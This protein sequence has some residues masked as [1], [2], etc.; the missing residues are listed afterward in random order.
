MYLRVHFTNIWLKSCVLRTFCFWRRSGHK[1]LSFVRHWTVFKTF[2]SFVNFR[3][4][5]FTFQSLFWERVNES[6]LVF[7]LSWTAES[8]ANYCEATTSDCN[9]A[10][11]CEICAQLELQ[12]EKKTDSSD[13]P[14]CSVPPTE[15][16]KRHSV[17]CSKPPTRVDFQPAA[18]SSLSHWHGRSTRRLVIRSWEPE[19]DEFLYCNQQLLIADSSR[20]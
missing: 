11:S 14:S 9:S 2:W 17:R 12:T 7:H 8:Y 10:P 5:T 13:T 19:S 18:P 1:W 16:H 15:K 6:H 3:L 4:S 20:Y